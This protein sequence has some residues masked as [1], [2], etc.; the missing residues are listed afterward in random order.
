MSIRGSGF[1]KSALNEERLSQGSVRFGE[2][3]VEVDRDPCFARDE[4][5]R[6]FV[7][8]NIVLRRDRCERR[9]AGVGARKLRVQPHRFPEL[10]D[11]IAEA[12]AVAAIKNRGR[13]EKE[14]VGLAVGR[15]GFHQ[16]RFLFAV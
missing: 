5:V 1:A 6:V 9:E 2:R 16:L 7:E 14:R 10:G 8:L 3:R 15:R 4:G 12:R 13:F 11:G